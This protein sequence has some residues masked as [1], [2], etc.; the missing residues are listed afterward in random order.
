MH[1]YPNSSSATLLEIQRQRLEI[2]LD[3]PAGTAYQPSRVGKFLLKFGQGLVHWLTNGDMPKVSKFTQGDIE[4][5]KVY[6][7]VISQALYFDNEV[8]LRIWMEQRYYQ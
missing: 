5:W 4:V 7:P 8:E 6:D 1:S 3:Y 2:L